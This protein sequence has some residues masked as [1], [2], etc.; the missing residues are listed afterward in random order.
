MGGA[1][2]IV[3][4]IALNVGEVRSIGRQALRRRLRRKVPALAG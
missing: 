3:S 1:I 2:Y 4:A